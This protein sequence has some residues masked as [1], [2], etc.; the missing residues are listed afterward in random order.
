LISQINHQKETIDE[1]E[2]R[3]TGMIAEYEKLK[4]YHNERMAEIDVLKKRLNDSDYRLEQ[5]KVLHEK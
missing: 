4:A 3:L 2:Q 5:E 1:L